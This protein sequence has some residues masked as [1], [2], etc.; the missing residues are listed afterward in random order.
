MTAV[1]QLC[2]MQA[3]VRPYLLFNLGNVL[4]DLD[5]P[6]PSRL[7]SALRRCGERLFLPFL[8]EHDW[9][10]A[11]ETGRWSDEHFLKGIL[12]YTPA[13]ADLCTLRDAWNAMLTRIPAVLQKGYE[14][15]VSTYTPHPR[16]T[17]ISR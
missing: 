6:A 16:I 11:Y 17:V 1:C 9:L 8:V 15:E 12:P 14:A 3:A 10:H 5:T 7:W 2:G 4:I 13:G